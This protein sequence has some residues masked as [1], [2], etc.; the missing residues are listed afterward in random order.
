MTNFFHLVSCSI[1]LN[2]A[3]LTRALEKVMQHRNIST[4][5]IWSTRRPLATCR[6]ALIDTV[7]LDPRPPMPLPTKGRTLRAFLWTTTALMP[8]SSARPILP[9]RF[10]Y[11][12]GSQ[13]SLPRLRAAWQS[14][15]TISR[16][17]Q[18]SDE[19]KTYHGN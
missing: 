15:T 3:L 14:A 6:E 11:K 17:T 19:R 8:C 5:P 16:R 2:Q 13:L 10:G 1:P 4:L 9:D 7:L 18:R 12:T